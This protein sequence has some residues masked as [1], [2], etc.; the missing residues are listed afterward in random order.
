MNILNCCGEALD[1]TRPKV[2]GILNVTPD[3]FYDGGKFYFIDDAIR[4]VEKMIKQEVD[5]IDI[6]AASSRPGSDDIGPGEEIRRLKDLLPE[7]SKSYPDQM[8]SID[9]YHRKVA[10]FAYENGVKILND[11]SAFSIDSSIIDFL[12]DSGMVR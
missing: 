8:L 3:S 10:E 1:L 5:I 9:T 4:R 6:G 2:M 7:I 12:R 11:I